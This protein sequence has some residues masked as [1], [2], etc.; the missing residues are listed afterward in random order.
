MLPPANGAHPESPCIRRLGSGVSNKSS[1]GAHE[2]TS[3]TV[4]VLRCLRTGLI[5][6]GIQNA[7]GHGV[8]KRE[9]STLKGPVSAPN[10]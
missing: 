2:S 10:L 6:V 3:G 8:Q 4:D 7:G 9:T 5:A 1:A